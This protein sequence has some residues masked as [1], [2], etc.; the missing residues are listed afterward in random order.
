MSKVEQVGGEDWAGG[1]RFLPR[2][3]F[4]GCPR[5]FDFHSACNRKAAGGL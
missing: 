2:Q 1:G 3:D 5:E 4:A